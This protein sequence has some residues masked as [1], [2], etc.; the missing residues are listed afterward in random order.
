[1]TILIIAAD[2]R[3][4][5]LLHRSLTDHGFSSTLAYNGVSGK[6]LALQNDY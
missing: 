1:M 3:V 6:K 4:A 5:E 2:L